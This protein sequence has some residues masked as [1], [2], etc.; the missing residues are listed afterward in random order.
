MS[1]S[2]DAAVVQVG[3]GK[4][5]WTVYIASGTGA[6]RAE[7]GGQWALFA[8]HKKSNVPLDMTIEQRL[9]ELIAKQAEINSQVKA[10]AGEDPA[11]ALL[12]RDPGLEAEREA[13]RP[14]LPEE[15]A[16]ERPVDRHRPPV[17]RVVAV[18]A[19]DAQGDG[20]VGPGERDDVARADAELHG[21]GLGDDGLAEGEGAPEDGPGVAAVRHREVAVRGHELQASRPDRVGSPVPRRLEGQERVDRRDAGDPLE[22]RDGLLGEPPERAG[23]PPALGSDEEVALQRLG[24]PVDDGRAERPDHHGHRDHHR[25]PHRERRD[26]DRGPR[27]APGQV[28][29]GDPRLDSEEADGRPVGDPGDG[30]DGERREE[31]EPRDDEEDGREE[32]EEQEG[33]QQQQ[34]AQGRAG[35]Y[36][37]GMTEHGYQVC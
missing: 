30:D 6:A 36:F 22:E 34:C 13:H 14:V 15:P 26:G 29:P 19:G 25:D 37:Q 24:D 10:E 2:A 7:P 18:D 35:V 5:H 28:R 21:V 31:R 32:Q 9:Q 8:A 11:P 4:T 12:G 1:C 23:R 20:T 27:E 16:E 33:Q 3:N 17:V